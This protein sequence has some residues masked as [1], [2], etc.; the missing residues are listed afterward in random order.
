MATGLDNAAPKKVKKKSP[1]KKRANG[2]TH[3]VKAKQPGQYI[4]KHQQKRI[5]VVALFCNCG[6]SILVKPDEIQDAP[7][8][9]SLCNS[10]FH[11]EQLAFP[12]D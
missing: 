8:L 3:V 1:K 2:A 12:L 11:W 10:A 7:I 9:C 4:Y 6:R 5:K